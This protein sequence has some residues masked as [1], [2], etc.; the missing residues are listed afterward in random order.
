M[1]AIAYGAKGYT[2]DLAHAFAQGCA[3]NGHPCEVRAA[4]AFD[5]VKPCDVVWMYGL[6]Y[7]RDIFNAYAGK[8]RRVIGDLG[9][10]RERAAELPIEKRPVRIA[11]DNEQPDLHLATRSHSLDRFDALR[12]FVQPVAQRGRHILLAG[13]SQEQA[14]LHGYAY[15]EWETKTAERLRAMTSRSVE[16]REK[17]GCPPI[18]IPGTR[19]NTDE[20]AA[21]AVR[22]AWAVVCRSGNIG[23]D[24]VLHGVPVFASAGPGAV[25]SKA[26]LDFIDEARPLTPGVRLRA[27]ADI[28]YCQWTPEEFASG[29]LWAHLRAESLI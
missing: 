23:A 18:I 15:G 22:K 10:W 2:A 21:Q 16:I 6:H 27:L 8:A 25:Y 13:H 29:A 20:S 12:L 24:A 14:E 11:V 5:G 4:D 19:R 7:T 9:Y 26:S 28:A 1:V 3:R 17:P